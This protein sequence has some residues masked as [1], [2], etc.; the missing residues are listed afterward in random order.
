MYFRG[1]TEQRD[2]RFHLI[3]SECPLTDIATSKEANASVL[4]PCEM[5]DSDAYCIEATGAS[6][7][8]DSSIGLI[9]RY[10]QKIGDKYECFLYVEYLITSTF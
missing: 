10:C 1:N 4:K 5:K 3:C 6:V 9:N 7:N 2:Q 8:V